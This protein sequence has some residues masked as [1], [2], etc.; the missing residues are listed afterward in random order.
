[1]VND[2]CHCGHRKEEHDELGCTHTEYGI[3]VRSCKCRYKHK[4][5]KDKL[6]KELNSPWD[7]NK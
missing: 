5:F 7:L 4:K 6:N 1:M 2:I 3:D